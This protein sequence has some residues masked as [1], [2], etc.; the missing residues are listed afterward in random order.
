MNGRWLAVAGV[1]LGVIGIANVLILLGF[2]PHRKAATNPVSAAA[3]V[4]VAA[5]VPNTVPQVASNAPAQ[6]PSNALPAQATAE[7]NSAAGSAHHHP[8]PP[9]IQAGLHLERQVLT[10]SGNLRVRYLRD[11]ERGLREIA[12]QD[13]HNPSNETILAE[14]KRTAWVVVSPNDDW[15]VLQKRDQ[16]ERAV[17][18]FHRVNSA[19]LKYEIP[20]ELQTNGKALRDVIWQ[21]YLEATHEDP[22]TDPQRVTIDATSWEPDSQKVTLSVTPIPTKSDT[23]LPMAWTCLYNVS[24]KQVESTSDEVTEQDQPESGSPNQAVADN[25]NAPA[26]E[27]A[28]TEATAGGDQTQAFEGEKFPATREEEITVQDANE[29]EL[30]D[31]KYAIFEMFARHGAEMHEA[32]MKKAFS[33]FSWYQPQEGLTFDQAEKEFSDIEKHNVVVLRRVRDAKLAAS[34]RP[35]HHAIRGQPVQ[36]ESNGERVL[37]GVLQGV[38]DALGNQ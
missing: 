15:I 35:E 4:A 20:P 27:N 3:P 34:H 26:A 6:S 17:Q 19:P 16:G 30:A 22:S 38:S 32:Q 1:G 36:E 13:A 14:Y 12:I 7:G 33:Q 18:L 29:L 21:S 23:T 10:V 37:R 8:T 9:P 31:V 2:G 5:A 24:T 25:S 11:R 28:D